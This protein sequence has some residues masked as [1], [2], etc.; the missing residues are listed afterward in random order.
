MKRSSKSAMFFKPTHVYLKL[1]T[2]QVWAKHLEY[3]VT[4]ELQADQPFTTERLLVGNF[5]AALAMTKAVLRQ[6][7]IRRLW[8][9]PRMVVHPLEYLE[10][11]LSP[12]EKRI[13]L[14]L[15]A[16]ANT[17]DVKVWEGK[18]LTDIQVVELFQATPD[19]R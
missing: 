13:F 6:V 15:G 2:N 17:L 7:I 14:E 1:R 12:V 8:V 3:Q 18:E 16:S 10:G 9:S 4:A 5:D 19:Q 11:G